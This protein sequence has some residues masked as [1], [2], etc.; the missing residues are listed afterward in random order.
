MTN[1]KKY[2]IVCY[3]FPYDKYEPKKFD[4]D[5]TSTVREAI[6][7]IQDFIQSDFENETLQEGARRDHS[8]PQP[9]LLGSYHY[10]DFLHEIRQMNIFEDLYYPGALVITSTDVIEEGSEENL[11]PLDPIPFVTDFDIETTAL[12]VFIVKNKEASFL[13]PYAQEE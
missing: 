4:L 8:K 13:W 11:N 10:N 7:A 3:E 1:D 5:P 6:D 9:F 12:R 2:T